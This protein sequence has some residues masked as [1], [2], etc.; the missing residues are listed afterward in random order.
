MPYNFLFFEKK[1]KMLTKLLKDHHYHFLNAFR[2]RMLEQ[3][4]IT[5]ALVTMLF[6]VLLFNGLNPQAHPWLK[7]LDMVL[8]LA[9]LGLL[10]AFRKHKVSR[11]TVTVLSLVL[12]LV[13]LN[14]V[15]YTSVNNP[16]RGVWFTLLV[17]YA[18][19]VGNKRLGYL[20]ALFT[21]L[22]F[23]IATATS[24]SALPFIELVTW[25]VAIVL[26]TYFSSALMRT[27]KRLDR[28]LHA[29]TNRYERMAMRDTLTGA[30]NR[31]A[32]MRYLN[33]AIH[34]AQLRKRNIALLYLDIDHFKQINDTYGHDIGD[35]VLK[36]FSETV[37]Q[38]IR[39]SDFFGRLGGEEF[40]IILDDISDKD[41][42]IKVA[43][44]IRQKIASLTVE[45][46][47]GVLKFT[48]SIGATLWESENSAQALLRKADAALYHAKT[49]GRNQ[50]CLA[51]N[52]DQKAADNT[53]CIICASQEE[54]KQTS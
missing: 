27:L 23:I 45:H 38:T 46:P 1:S 48:V 7:W 40:V 50:T 21:T 10:F 52:P 33:R 35:K 18:F 6:S 4:L 47:K 22:S 16:A 12:G 30:H 28:I 5:F 36:T 49:H 9:N 39:I 26:I 34:Q 51:Q 3:V 19:I 14:F 54:N 20:T 13:L 53:P 43:E 32:L 24:P 44:K 25:L 29:R 15:L 2:V 17:L 31:R 11:L 37:N 8:A 41:T 42:L